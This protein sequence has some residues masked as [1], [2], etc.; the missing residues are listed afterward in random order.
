MESV[1]S[2]GQSNVYVCTEGVKNLS[3]F[4]SLFAKCELTLLKFIVI[5]HDFFPFHDYS[6]PSYMNKHFS[7]RHFGE[8]PLAP[9]GRTP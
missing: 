6:I 7:V 5:C 3:I 2:Y 4:S 8:Q 9:F 1:H